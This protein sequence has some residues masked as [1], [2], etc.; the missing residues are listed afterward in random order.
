MSQKRTCWNYLIVFFLLFPA[1][2]LADGLPP[3]ASK[4]LKV[5]NVSQS[6]Q[7]AQIVGASPGDVLRYEF[8]IKSNTEPVD[9]YVFSM[10]ISMIFKAADLIDP[11]SGVLSGTALVYPAFSHTAPCEQVFT[12]FVRVKSDCG[13]LD[14]IISVAEGQALNVP[15][16]CGIVHMT[17][18]NPTWGDSSY[19]VGES[20][21]ITWT[22]QGTTGNYIISLSREGGKNGTFETI[23]EVTNT[24]V[25]PWTVTG[26]AANNCVLKIEP[27][28]FP[29]KVAHTL[30]NIAVPAV[31]TF[32]ATVPANYLGAPSHK[33]T[34]TPSV[35]FGVNAVTGNFFHAEAD[36]AM[37]GKD[38]SFTFARAYN[39]LADGKDS[40]DENLPQPLGPGWT[41]GYNIVLRTNADKSLAEVI[42]GDGHHDGFGK[43]DSTWH[44][45]TPGNFSSLA[46]ITGQSY[47]WE[48]TTKGQIRY[49][50]NADGK[51][52]AIIGR[53]S[54][55]MNFTYTGSDLTGITDT[56]DRTITLTY[57]A[58]LLTR[59]DLPPSRHFDFEYTAAGLLSS[60]IDMKGNSHPYV[61][62]TNKKLIQMHRANQNP[63]VAV[64][65][66]QIT[67]NAAGRVSE[68]KTG[69]NIA[70]PDTGKY[71]FG[72]G[73]NT[74]QYRSPTGKGSNY[75]WDAN[76]RV[77]QITPVNMT[78]ASPLALTYGSDTG[79][80]SVL[81]DTSTDFK[82]KQY[83]YVFE[84]PNLKTFT[85]PLSQTS[86]QSWNTKNDMTGFQTPAELKTVISP[87]VFGSPGSLTIAAQGGISSPI[88]ASFTYYSETATSGLPDEMNIPATTQSQAV[89]TKVTSYSDDGQPLEVHRYVNAATILKTF[90]AYD[91]AGRLKGQKDHRGTWSC[92]YYDANDNVSNVVSGLTDTVC[93]A[94]PPNA[95]AT[96]RHIQIEYDAD[97]RVVKR[98]TGQGSTIRRDMTYQYGDN[99]GVLAH[100]Y[101]HG[102]SR[103][104]EFRYDN[105]LVLAKVIE[106]GT[107]REDDFFHHADNRLRIS[108]ENANQSGGTLS[109]ITRRTYDANGQPETVSSCTGL[110]GVNECT[111]T[112]ERLRIIRDDLGRPTQIKE[113]VSSGVYRVSNYS[114]EPVQAKSYD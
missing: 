90:Y 9:A 61:Y 54:H 81:P 18:S 107:A 110:D 49:R 114:S 6:N 60:V 14:R 43:T 59:V 97:N 15:L 62:D 52:T 2:S 11:G 67:Y 104:R 7:N 45:D 71:T 31:D 75:T 32:F 30:F 22:T 20:S 94:L 64:P 25:Y 106:D 48:L 3:S 82:G 57:N 111:G 33:G 96:V 69:Y 83:A 27:V 91:E 80:V 88:N 21:I 13:D 70:N 103:H 40:F 41:H 78:D 19:I 92:Y 112:V 113:T 17:I 51:L 16:N 29:N 1:A 108:V 4:T 58:G 44:G 24:F 100:V 86:E 105:D 95:S 26:P 102:M 79:A 77:T 34:S 89:K 39:S 72:W 35:G 42:W 37:P 101:D 12:F 76:L 56:A 47:A 98:S 87:T 65:L 55:A 99:S 50:F 8:S 93:P 36:A 46:E 85:D 68:Q 53:S 73:S 63:G 109:R 23:G 84:G 28:D 5:L 66:I 74:L 38:I 10:D